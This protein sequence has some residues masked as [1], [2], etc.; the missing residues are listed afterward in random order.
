ML[1]VATNEVDETSAMHYFIEYTYLPCMRWQML[2]K[3]KE[4]SNFKE[5]FDS[6]NIF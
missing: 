3:F 1:Q 5:H 2:H 4:T 6:L